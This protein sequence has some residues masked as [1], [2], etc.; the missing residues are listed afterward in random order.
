MP[1]ILGTKRLPDNI[2]DLNDL[3][4]T[5]SD[6]LTP[7]IQA[8]DAGKLIQIKTDE[9]GFEIN[10]PISGGAKFITT[11]NLS[12]TVSNLIADGT[13]YE[14]TASSST[15]LDPDAT[16]LTYNW[17]IAQGDLTTP[18][19]TSTNAYFGLSQNDSTVRLTC[20][21]TDD[22]GN[23]SAEAIL[24]LE[25]LATAVPSG[26]SLSVPSQFVI[27]MAEQLD[28]T[29]GDDGGDPNNISYSWEISENDGS[30]WI[31]TGLSNSTIKNPTMTFTTT[32]LT[33][34]VR[35]TVSNS[36][37]PGITETSG[38]L[39]TVDIIEDSNSQ[40]IDSTAHLLSAESYEASMQGFTGN[41]E[42]TYADGSGMW[43]GSVSS[44]L[45][46][47]KIVVTYTDSDNSNILTT[48]IGT[49]SGTTINWGTGYTITGSESTTYLSNCV[50]GTDKVVVTYR[51]VNNSSYGTAV[52]GAITGT[53]IAFGTPQ[54][55]KSSNI[56]AHKAAAAGTN[57]FVV[58]YRM[59]GGN[60]EVIIGSISGTVITFG[61]PAGISQTVEK[62]AIG[63]V[64]TDK[65]VVCY[66]DN[67]S[68]RVATLSGT[69]I[70][71]QS[72]VVFDPTITIANNTTMT[73]LDTNEIVICYTGTD[74]SW[75]GRA[76]SGTVSG[77]TISFGSSVVLDP[78]GIAHND[79]TTASTSIARIVYRDD[80]GKK[81][82]VKD[83]TVSGNTITV[84]DSSSVTD[85]YD[86]GFFNIN[87]VDS[88]TV[89]TYKADATNLGQSLVITPPDSKTLVMPT[90][91]ALN[92]DPVLAPSMNEYKEIILMDTN[93]ILITATS[94][95][96][97]GAAI[98]DV[99]GNTITWGTV[100][101]T[102]EATQGPWIRTIKVDSSTFVLGYG[103]TSSAGKSV[104]GKIT[105]NS[106]SFG[107]PVTFYSNYLY[108]PDGCL[109]DTN[110]VVIVYRDYSG[111][112]YESRYSVGTISGSDISFG[113][114]TVISSSTRSHCTA[115]Q[116]ETNKILYTENPWEG[117]PVAVRVGTFNGST[118]SWG[119]VANYST[120]YAGRTVSDTLDTNKIILFNVSSSG[121]KAAVATVSG[122]TVT[123]GS[124][125]SIPLAGTDIYV[126]ALSSEEVIFS[127]LGAY[128]PATIS[129]TTITLG[130]EILT[131]GTGYSYVRALNSN[132]AVAWYKDGDHY[133]D[134]LTKGGTPFEANDKIQIASGVI[135]TV[136][137]VSGDMSENVVLT[138]NDAA[139]GT[140]YRLHA[141]YDVPTIEQ[142][143]GEDDFREVT[144][145]AQWDR[146]SMSCTE[147]TGDCKI[148]HG[149]IEMYPF[150]NGD[151]V[152]VS[153]D[154]DVIT[155]INA[156][157][158]RTSEAG[159]GL[160]GSGTED[161]FASSTVDQVNA[162][163]AGDN[164]VVVVWR[165]STGDG[166]SCV[167]V[168][169]GTNIS[170]GSPVTYE[171]NSAY[172]N[173][174]IYMGND[175]IIVFFDRD[176]VD[177]AFSIIGTLNGTSISWESAI[178]L[179]GPASVCW[180]LDAVVVDTNKFVLTYRGGN[181]YGTSVVGEFNGTSISSWGTEVV[182]HSVT[183][184]MG[185][186]VCVG[187][188]AVAVAY[189]IA[190]G[191]GSCRVCI[192][193]VSGTVITWGSPVS[194]EGSSTVNNTSIA[195]VGN[196]KIVALYEVSSVGTAKVGTV[197]TGSR[198]VSF[199][200]ASV[201]KNGNISGIR[202]EPIGNDRLVVTYQNDG[203]GSTG[204]SNLGTVT[205][206]D[207]SWDSDLEF[208]STTHNN[209]HSANTAEIG[210]NQLIAIYR[211]A[212]NSSYGTSALITRDDTTYFSTI[213]T[214]D[215]I[216][217]NTS[218]IELLPVDL[219]SDLNDG[220]K[221]LQSMT[222]TASVVNSGTAKATATLSGD[223]GSLADISVKATNTDL[224]DVNITRIEA[225]FGV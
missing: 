110:K 8:G 65:L 36:A 182:Y 32:G 162:T 169:S 68:A 6:K 70:T 7:E 76:V 184:T 90:E 154:T 60:A 48:K 83:L 73:V 102:T 193:T 219:E 1:S 206:T 95:S 27:N 51:N 79:I 156:T 40:F 112:P 97:I 223:Q 128:M 217:A 18:T 125:V 98:G 72:E 119:T 93:R 199:G 173:A 62:F 157:P 16:V 222:E 158:S 221:V 174:I 205:G 21:A 39:A 133:I 201:F 80:D 5:V 218:T 4:D 69:A 94:G 55:F 25:V 64:D 121:G 211:D 210:E 118:F 209:G 203:G 146:N 185:K 149:G 78:L 66:E 189:Y 15:M 144:I 46:T 187:T 87:I 216:P 176:G 148:D 183:A 91:L 28:I 99:S 179:P 54:V 61:S 191:S 89:V 195:Y 213:S 92:G 141:S 103:V 2:V 225:D 129:G 116:L 43:T 67:F 30:S 215:T 77:N 220:T 19:G 127:Y 100:E 11:P 172:Y 135:D 35:C 49:I 14:Y 81:S 165:D 58:G 214:T 107:T 114:S 33:V 167:G 136:A 166:I 120:S 13:N 24:D 82:I 44:G 196:D 138:D 171:T 88:G 115:I 131:G 208:N 50:V 56:V 194:A 47:D 151:N 71:L 53:T 132:K 63:Y 124:E 31:T 142:D 164:R 168:I 22:Q 147:D 104:V 170:W 177:V 150:T 155:T 130:D 152:L 23:D 122:T 224:N 74:G 123:I 26:L 17:S 139:S 45:G 137:S 159:T 200:S 153:G 109:I 212:G 186:V 197:N 41:A 204:Y 12:G 111:S 161:I 101:L 180:E 108:Y 34:K 57:R 178:N 29:V 202:A 42:V 181:Q 143:G 192:G 59:D 106:I 9:T 163:Y 207:V 190:S 160:I 134:M 84:G 145:E 37:G 126:S 85:T 105:G 188:N 75:R 86:H 117:S 175:K 3:K 113:T 38:S 198:T 20:Y 140:I 10:Q 96:T 52:V